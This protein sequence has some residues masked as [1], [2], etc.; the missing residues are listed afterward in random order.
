MNEAEHTSTNEVSKSTRTSNCMSVENEAEKKE[1]PMMW[2]CHY[3]DTEF[4]T[5]EGIDEG[6]KAFCSVT[7]YEDYLSE[8]RD[9]G[10]VWG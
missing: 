2:F 9:R 8:Q 7:C 5:I 1:W 10:E 4:E 3:C 6:S